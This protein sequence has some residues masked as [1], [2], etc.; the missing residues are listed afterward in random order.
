MF[1]DLFFLFSPPSQLPATGANILPFPLPPICH[2]A[3]L[4][5]SPHCHIAQFVYH[6][7]L[8]HQSGIRPPRFSF[9]TF[10]SLPN[11]LI[12]ALPPKLITH[13]G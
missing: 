12:K 3:V 11:D 13:S 5:F 2:G 6:F 8:L 9:D 1:H 10:F 7:Q 4:L